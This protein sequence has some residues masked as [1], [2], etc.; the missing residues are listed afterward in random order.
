[1]RATE[2]R[3]WFVRAHIPTTIFLCTE[4]TD[5]AELRWPWLVKTT[6]STCLPRL[7]PRFVAYSLL[8]DLPGLHVAILPGEVIAADPPRHRDGEVT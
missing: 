2:A 6:E 3:R 7:S 4:S 8:R 1:M 5:T